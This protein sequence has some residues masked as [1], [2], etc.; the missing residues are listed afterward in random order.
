MLKQS[1]NFK[2]SQKLSPQHAQ[3]DGAILVV[4]CKIKLQEE[5]TDVFVGF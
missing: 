1:L 2:L 4:A 5:N 3:M